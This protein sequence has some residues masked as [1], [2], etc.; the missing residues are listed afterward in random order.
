MSYSNARITLAVAAICM[1]AAPLLHAADTAGTA[2]ADA[3]AGTANEDITLPTVV[4]TAEQ[5]NQ[6][7]AAIETQTGA[8]TY[9]HR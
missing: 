5:L 6:K 7:R 3:T 8:S 4:V 1:L 9:T 2:D